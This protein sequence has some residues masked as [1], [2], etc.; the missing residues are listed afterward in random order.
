MRIAL[1]DPLGFT[2][3]YDDR[4]ASALGHLGHDVHLLTAP[5]L[6]DQPPEPDGY[7][8]EE[9]F[10]PVSSRLLR[11]RPRARYRTIVKAVE[12]PFGVRRI[13]HRIEA[14]TPD[15][16]HFQ[17]LVRPEFDVYWLRRVADRH[18]T[19]LTAHNA[20][21]RRVKAYT[22]WRRALD[23]VER[24]VVTSRHAVDV[25]SDFGTSR[26]KIVHIPHPV[27]DTPVEHPVAEP[28]G[29]TLL[30]FGLIRQHKGLDVLVAAM[31]EIVRRVPEARLVVAGDPLE[32]ITPIKELAS[33]LG[34]DD[35]IDWRLGFIPDV[36]VAP[37][38]GASTVV[39]LPYRN[40]VYSGVLSLALGH[41]RPVVVSDLGSV[42]DT[43]R[44]F[45]AGSVVP[46]EDVG[47]LA[48]ACVKLL[49]D[50]PSLT[51]AF[52]G[53]LSARAALTWDHAARAHERLYEEIVDPIPAAAAT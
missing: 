31:R 41:G 32:P 46:P 47:A 50:R 10:I 48:D 2:T 26:D 42:G 43:V 35:S 36:E 13:L 29:Q 5:F 19:V 9:L 37:L 21:P 12:Y 25:V 45:G 17:W 33:S 49:T 1:V 8:R 15:A 22:A 4:L 52:Q 28:S 11:R 7:V 27:F 38:L 23:A 34:V 16:V 18:P 51:R 20:L 39:V 6:L 3:P 14:L 24:V 40:I 44:D 53:A 30:F